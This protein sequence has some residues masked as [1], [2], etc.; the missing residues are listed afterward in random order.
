MKIINI[1]FLFGIIGCSDK[2]YETSTLIGKV[3]YVNNIDNKYIY[4]GVQ[5]SQTQIY[6]IVDSDLKDE[7]KL[8]TYLSKNV[9][10]EYTDYMTFPL[11]PKGFITSIGE[12]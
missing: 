4:L 1:V 5:V 7:T 9:K 10:I 2:P 6:E 11:P 3:V 8:K 12:L